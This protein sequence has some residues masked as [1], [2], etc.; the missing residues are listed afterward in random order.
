MAQGQAGHGGEL[1]RQ[2][3]EA[4][5]E[6]RAVAVTAALLATACFPAGPSRAD[7]GNI[8]PRGN[9]GHIVVRPSGKH[10]IEM[11]AV[12]DSSYIVESEGRIAE[13]RFLQVADIA[14]KGFG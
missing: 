4:G 14:L 6:R 13:V 9:T 10:P 2:Q 3:S 8:D 1:L 11:L 5:P 12:T 7:I